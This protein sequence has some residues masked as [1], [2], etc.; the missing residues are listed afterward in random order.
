MPGLDRILT[1][2]AV[3]KT[4]KTAEEKIKEITGLDVVL[5]AAVKDPFTPQEAADIEL[6]KQIITKHTHIEWHM[7]TT[8]QGEQRFVKARRYFSWIYVKVL[9]RSTVECASLF[10]MHHTSIVDYLQLLREDKEN[11]TEV[12][13]KLQTIINDF[14]NQRTKAHATHKA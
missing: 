11:N 2:P 7:L 14:E 1:I 10:H 12:W 3:T 9:K 13:Q 6:L 8:R 4:L 5:R